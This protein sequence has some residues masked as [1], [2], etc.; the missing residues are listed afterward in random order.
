M[1]L[2]WDEL[3][4]NL[5]YT[6]IYVTFKV[7]YTTGH[8]H[9]ALYFN[10]KSIKPEQCEH[11]DMWIKQIHQNRNGTRNMKTVL[12]CTN[13]SSF[14]LILICENTYESHSLY[15][16]RAL[17]I[18][19]PNLSPVSNPQKPNTRL[20]KEVGAPQKNKPQDKMETGFRKIRTK[21]H[22]VL[23]PLQLW[24]TSPSHLL[25]LSVLW[26]QL[27]NHVR[28]QGK[29]R[30]G[31]ILGHSSLLWFWNHPETQRKCTV[32]EWA[33]LKKTPQ[34]VDEW[35]SL[36]AGMILHTGRMKT[37]LLHLLNLKL[38]TVVSPQLLLTL[39]DSSASHAK[40]L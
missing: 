17:S 13:S 10:K 30:G 9:T 35:R 32:I 23:G 18:L 22:L 24:L 25:V 27:H 2:V 11:C 37:R 14:D 34:K 5:V 6:F 36:S 1:K 20:C 28:S 4:V 33:N 7:H 26:G 21:V 39:A 12:L 8:S 19:H 38:N 15:T 31:R 29:G 40:M 16:L 3:A